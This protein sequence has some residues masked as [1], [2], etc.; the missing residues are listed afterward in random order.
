MTF[1]YRVLGCVFE[2]HNLWLLGV[3]V[4]LCV[5]ACAG[6]FFVLSSV[7]A[8]NR[9]RGSWLFLAALVA[10]GGTWATH[11]VAMLGYQPGLP[12]GFDFATTLFSSVFCVAFAWAAF[13]VF[14]YFGSAVG[15][16]IAGALLGVGIAGMHY[17]GMAGLDAP[18]HRMWASDLVIASAIFSVGFA[19]AALYAFALA[20]KRYRAASASALLITAILSLHFTGMGAVTLELDPRV[21]PANH[22][23]DRHLLAVLVA[24][25]AAATLLIGIVLAFADRQVAASKL[26]AAEQAAAAALQD[27]LTGLPNRRHLQETLNRAL[28][29]ASPSAPLAVV[30]VDLDRFKPVNDLYGH[31]VGDELLVRIGHILSN[32]AGEG[33]F[34][35]RLGGDEFV[36]LLSYDSEDALIDR[37]GALAAKFDEPMPLQDNEVAVG[38]TLGVA[39]APADGVEADVLMRRA[40]VA[41]YR[42]KGDGRGRFTFYEHGMEERMRER[43]ALEHDLRRAIRNDEIV[44][45]FQPRRVRYA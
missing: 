8:N 25:C 11:F 1:M 45:H 35:A 12:I 24:G 5:I 39:L 19:I 18:A 33:G 37:L 30:A 31:A 43:A 17:I 7:P 32:E 4:L 20:P 42:A 23:L 14:H 41:L 15:R 22:A 36:L 21:L 27:A 2:E 38:A 28:A 44:P 29:N 10:G 3:A 9:L 13:V 6:A 34:V 16:T 26:A 40:D